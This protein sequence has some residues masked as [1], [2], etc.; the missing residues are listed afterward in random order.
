MTPKTPLFLEVSTYVCAR[1]GA[2][3][4][5]GRL[6]GNYGPM[7]KYLHSN[8]WLPTIAFFVMRKRDENEG[9]AHPWCHWL[10]ILFTLVNTPKYWAG[11][12]KTFCRNHNVAGSKFCN[13]DSRPIFDGYF[14][15]NGSV[16]SFFGQILSDPPLSPGH[17]P[18]KL[19]EATGT[20]PCWVCLGG[21]RLLWSHL[22]LFFFE[23]SGSLWASDFAQW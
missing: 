13:N 6:I 2:K 17:P 8:K 23:D 20:E 12:S 7:D 5:R 19:R 4:L 21:L 10:N 11:L 16:P 15:V 22:V 14:P 3:V 18:K 9:A 1:G